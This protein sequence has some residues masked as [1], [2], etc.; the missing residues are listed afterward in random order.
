MTIERLR[1]IG[2]PDW[3]GSKAE[4]E[5]CFDKYTAIMAGGFCDGCDEPLD[6][7]GWNACP[8]DDG[9][10]ICGECDFENP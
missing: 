7:D 3:L 6:R 2:V 9:S 8:Q 10:V 5:A 4:L 1:E